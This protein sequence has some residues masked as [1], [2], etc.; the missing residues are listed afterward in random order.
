MAIDEGKL[1][2]FLGQIVVDAGAA[3]STV[4]VDIGERLGIYRALAEGGG[5]TSAELAKRTGVGERL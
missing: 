2:A 4:L 5:Q 1:E 3:F